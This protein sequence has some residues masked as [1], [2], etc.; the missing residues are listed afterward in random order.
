DLYICVMSTNSTFYPRTSIGL[1]NK[2]FLMAL[3][4]FFFLF[5]DISRKKGILNKN[6]ES[7]LLLEPFIDFFFLNLL[8][9]C[10]IF[11]QII[12]KEVDVWGMILTHESIF[13]ITIYTELTDYVVFTWISILSSNLVEYWEEQETIRY[14]GMLKNMLGQEIIINMIWNMT[15]IFFTSTLN[16]LFLQ[17]KWITRN[18]SST[19]TSSHEIILFILILEENE[20]EEEEEEEAP[21]KNALEGQPIL[22]THYDIFTYHLH[23]YYPT[24]LM[25][26]RE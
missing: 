26:M 3:M 19:T 16:D 12:C 25:K 21:A 15:Q 20:D 23:T 5:W 9:L 6:I 1:F 17:N 8:N 7:H 2:A 14:N 10:C 22:S 4:H 18:K 11:D 24:L 13:T